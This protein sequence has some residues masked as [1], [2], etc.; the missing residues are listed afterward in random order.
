MEA[1]QNRW[2]NRLVEQL[3]LDRSMFQL[4]IPLEPKV[5]SDL[6]LWAYLNFIPPI[7]LTRYRSGIVTSFFDEYASLASQLKFPTDEFRQEIGEDNF[8]AWTD[9]LEGQSP[10][11]AAGQLPSLFLQWA[12]TF[13]PEVAQIGASAL[14]QFV[15]LHA[16]HGALSPYLGTEGKPADF[17]NTYDQ[18][19]NTLDHSHGRKLDFDS[20]G[21]T[22]EVSDTWSN[23]INDIGSGIWAANPPTSR[24]GRLFARHVVNVSVEFKAYANLP[25]TPGAWY[26]SGLFQLAY[27]SQG[28]QPWSSDA[29]PDW[30]EFFGPQGSM[31]YL[32]ASLVAVDGIDATLSSEAHCTPADQD[33][34][35]RHA[36]D[37]LWPFYCPDS[38][39]CQNTVSFD[40]RG[41]M[42][43]NTRI[44]PGNPCFLGVNVLNCARYLGHSS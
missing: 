44:E 2:Y 24:M 21:T 23:G 18:L 38:D 32:P 43:L 4:A 19:L 17:L 3:D 15:L 7:S 28:S 37:G 31:Q 20:A 14:S 29:N 35:A 25:I 30:Q 27:S 5:A 39:I 42:Q 9:F 41:S 33:L 26:N 10:Q 22:G 40:Q 1:L 6:A 36:R 11:P 13:A 8:A 34:I 16:G 12:I